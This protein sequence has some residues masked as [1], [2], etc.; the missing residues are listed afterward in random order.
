M[1]LY[2]CL[3]YNFLF[4]FLLFDFVLAQVN[5]AKYLQLF[6]FFALLLHFLP[7]L[8]CF[9]SLWQ[10]IFLWRL[11]CR[12]KFLWQ[13]LCRLICLRPLQQLYQ[14]RFLLQQRQI[15]MD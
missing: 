7:C 3:F 13:L 9:F 8:F 11:R 12:L 14:P 6:F 10:L 1:N 2:L 4:I 5:V 15:I